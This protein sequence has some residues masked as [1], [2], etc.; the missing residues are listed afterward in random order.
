MRW[1][2]AFGL[3]ALALSTAVGC[4][5]RKTPAPDASVSQFVGQA[6]KLDLEGQQTAAIAL[7]RQALARQSDS[8]DA[9]YGIGRALDLAGSYDEARQ[10]FAR[11]IELAPEGSRDQAL[12]MMGIAWT[13]VANVDQAARYFHEVFDRRVAEAN[14]ATAA[15]EADELGR[16]YLESGDLDRAE[17]WYQTGHETA[18]R[19]PN[20]PASQVDLADL[21]WAH[22]RARIAARRGRAAEARRQEMLVSRLLDK[23]GNDDQRIQ[24]L[25]LR[26]YVDF[27]LGH[28]QAA[29]TS[30]EQA[31]QQDPLVLVLLGLASDQLE[32]PDQARAYYRRVLQ[33]SSHAVNSAFA[34]PIA[35]QK[36]G[37]GG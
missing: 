21:R 35:R 29:L 5:P 27:Y 9:H 8:F 23:G 26:G 30:L 22:A 20:R 28:P 24:Y 37:P 17:T 12:R 31:D 18:G 19:A 13:F 14:P 2:A 15:E 16:V 11:A 25:Y 32:R 6:R 34:R 3:L 1:R 4:A 33:S 36:L 10:H 7:Y